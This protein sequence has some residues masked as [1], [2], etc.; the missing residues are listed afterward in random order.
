MVSKKRIFCEDCKEPF[1]LHCANAVEADLELLLIDGKSKYKYRYDFYL[2]KS[3]NDDTTPISTQ[4]GHTTIVNRNVNSKNDDKAGNND[5]LIMGESTHSS[6][7]GWI[8]SLN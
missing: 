7:L 5:T 8:G 6:I 1:Y 2:R 4:A 3:R